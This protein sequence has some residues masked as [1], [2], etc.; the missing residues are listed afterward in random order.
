MTKVQVLGVS[1]VRS[2][3]RKWDAQVRRNCQA[4]IAEA[5]INIQRMAKEACPV[6]T[7]RLRSSIAIRFDASGFAAEVGTN[8][9]YAPAVEFG[10]MRRAPKPFL[11]PA[12]E[13]ERPRFQS[14]IKRAVMDAA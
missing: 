1:E 12:F 7:G 9:H 5:A 11:F 13:R 6:K 3:L 14:A 4:A 10:G 8:V 2:A